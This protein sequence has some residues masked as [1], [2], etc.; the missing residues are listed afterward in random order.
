M[1]GGI[2]E[3]V[4][5]IIICKADRTA[6]TDVGRGLAPAIRPALFGVGSGLAPTSWGCGLHLPCG[7]FGVSRNALT[8]F[9]EIKSAIRAVLV[10]LC[11]IER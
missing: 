9:R 7:R 10:T 3:L 11:G 5:K 6:Q 4:V 2:I 1:L 8:L